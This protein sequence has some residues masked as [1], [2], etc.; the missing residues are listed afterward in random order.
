MSKRRAVP[1]TPASIPQEALPPLLLSV[2]VDRLSGRWAPA[3]VIDQRHA[4]SDVRILL[5]VLRQVE[6]TLQDD[7]VRMAEQRGL[8]AAR[9]Q[10]EKPGEAE[11][12]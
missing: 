5:A 12:A 11:H 10:A 9:S 2:A 3:V 6:Q 7:L 1:S 8:A 4:E